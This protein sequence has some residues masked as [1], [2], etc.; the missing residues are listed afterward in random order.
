MTGANFFSGMN[1]ATI[2]VNPS[3]AD[4]PSLIQASGSAT[5]TGDN[6]VA[7]QLAQ[8]ASA[9]QVALNGQTFGDA[10]NQSVADLG[11]ALQYANNQVTS[12]T[13]VATMLSTQRS[14]ISGVNVDEEMTNLMS[15]QRAYAAS[16]ELVKT[17]DQMIQT[18]LSIKT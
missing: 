14:S 17:V 2:T 7:L 10:Y 9:A 18:V 12:Q 16:A 13:A 6:S 4:N 1:A 5:A 15:Y 3:L 8:L 11:N